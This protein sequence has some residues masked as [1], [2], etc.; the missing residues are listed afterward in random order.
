MVRTKGAVI[1]GMVSFLIGGS[2]YADAPSEQYGDWTVTQLTP[3]SYIALTV[4]N[5]DARFGTFC[6]PKMCTAFF[7]NGSTCENGAK[8]PVLLNS[9]SGAY[10]EIAVCEKIGNR[11]LLEMPL[12]GDVSNAMSV[13]GT[14]G[15]AFPMQSG[16]FQVS[17]FSM[18]G[19]ARASARASQLAQARPANSQQPATDNFSL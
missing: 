3:G 19:A 12:Q 9:P 4:N 7:D 16:Q 6:S 14:L 13:G 2:A 10:P 5:G 11:H 17:R 1:A 18:T 8:Y 15:I